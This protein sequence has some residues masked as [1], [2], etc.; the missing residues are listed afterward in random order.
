MMSKIILFPQRHADAG[1][2]GDILCEPR[3]PRLLGDREVGVKG[4]W[5]GETVSVSVNSIGKIKKCVGVGEQCR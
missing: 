3:N 1:I 4:V 5:D 2:S